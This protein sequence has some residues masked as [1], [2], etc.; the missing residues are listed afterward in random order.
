V[1]SRMM[2]AAVLSY[3]LAGL[4]FNAAFLIQMRVFYALKSWSYFIAMRSLAMVLK[5]L[6]GFYFIKSN[7]A[8][9]LGGGTTVL[10]AFAF[11]SLE[12]YLVL[13]KGL[14]Y[15]PEDRALLSKAF[16]A[17]MATVA[18]FAGSYL[19]AVTLLDLPHLAAAVV[20][21]VAGCALLAVIDWK[22]HVSG[23]NWRKYLPGSR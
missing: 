18:L 8:L 3:F 4:F 22:L 5:C 21:G 23:V 13:K 12:I 7:W 1:E 15:S 9:A 14:A 17:A 2:T 6:I 20:T 16:L 11:I 19:V 10:F